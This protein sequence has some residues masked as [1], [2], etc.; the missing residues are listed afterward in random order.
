M[1]KF[2]HFSFNNPKIIIFATLLIVVFAGLQLPRIKVDTDPENMLPKSEF[3]RVFHD[4]TKK[5]FS[6]YDFIV[7][8]VINDKHPQGV[9]NVETLNK[10]YDITEKIKTIDGV[11]DREIIAI[12]TKDNIR[13]GAA[14][15]VVF[16]WLMKNTIATEEEAA[17]IRDEAVDNPMFN[18]TLISEDA[19]ALCVYI[20][21]KQKNV[22]YAVSQEIFKIIKTFSGDEQYH[23]TGL[24][25]AEDTFGIEMF[26][27]MAVSAPLAGL[28]IF[29]LMWVFFKNIKLIISPMV[30][31]VV[32]VITTMGLLIGFG[33][34]V[35]I[36]SSMIPIFLMPIA[37]LDSVH[38]LSEFFDK[39]RVI[40][41]KKD[42]IFKVLD[43]LF[44]P[45]LYTSLTS[46]VGFLSLSFS[47][48]PPVQTFGVFVAIGIMIAW[49]LT[50]TF[51]PAYIALISEKSLKN[52]TI[53]GEKEVEHHGA[54]D[55]ILSGI[56]QFS[57]KYAKR[58]VALSIVLVIISGYGISKIRVND[59]PVRWF[60]K[61]HR[62]RVADKVLNEHFSGT[63]TA[64]LVLSAKEK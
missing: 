9:F 18:G 42:T 64:Y 58:V 44:T 62:I 25:V 23:I 16:E 31:A 50:M 10:V 52:L 40:G 24:P 28:I 20:P 8:G 6:I 33:F 55:D 60:T 49:I 7:L 22:S 32:T 2:I 34:P 12:S 11:I 41:N 57:V 38:I 17:N 53:K 36:M 56:R 13:Q 3:V 47:P 27:Q 29:I 1:K 54:I 59:N 21:I 26:K 15:E 19:K 14:G 5:E 4:E 46:A 63:Y 45:M 48:L 35:H 43:E 61:N 39:Y 30:L 37:V 51:I